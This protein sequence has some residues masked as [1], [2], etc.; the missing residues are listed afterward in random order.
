MLLAAVHKSQRGDR[1][2]RRQKESGASVAHQDISEELQKIC[3]FLSSEDDV[4]RALA[5]LERLLRGTPASM[6]GTVLV[7]MPT[8]IRNSRRCACCIINR[9]RTPH[10]VNLF[11]SL[12]SDLLSDKSFAIE[13]VG[14]SSDIYW[15]LPPHLQRDQQVFSVFRKR[16]GV[17][18][19]LT[20]PR[21]KLLPLF[22]SQAR[23]PSLAPRSSPN[24][25]DMESPLSVSKYCVRFPSIV[26]AP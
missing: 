6:L 5:L 4:D 21:K 24:V 23:L 16:R 19:C 3:K 17:A 1:F 11:L 10:H 18:V 26:E 2:R 15:G 20:P 25:V 22:H 7:R 12:F 8:D 13:V 14:L 9:L